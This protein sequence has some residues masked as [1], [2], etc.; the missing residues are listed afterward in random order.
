MHVQIQVV[1]DHVDLVPGRGWL[2]LAW[3]QAEDAGLVVEQAG[4]LFEV[5]HD[6]AR[7]SQR[8]VANAFGN[9]QSEAGAGERNHLP[10][11]KEQAR[12]VGD[13]SVNVAPRSQREQHLPIFALAGE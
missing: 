10:G 5:D 6:Q 13:E 4:N 3:V 8:L 12:V 1:S 9:D 2:Q 11:E 7:R